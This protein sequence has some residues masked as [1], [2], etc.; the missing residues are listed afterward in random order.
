M[1][2]NLEIYQKALIEIRMTCLAKKQCV[3]YLC[4]HNIFSLGVKWGVICFLHYN[5]K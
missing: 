1:H 5:I 4:I 2:V 3:E